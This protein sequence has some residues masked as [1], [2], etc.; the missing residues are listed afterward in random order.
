MSNKNLAFLSC[1]RIGRQKIHRIHRSPNMNP[2]R[3]NM[4]K[5]TVTDNTA[6][7]ISSLPLPTPQ[8]GTFLY[9]SPPEFPTFCLAKTCIPTKMEPFAEKTRKQKSFGPGCHFD[10]P[11][12]LSQRFRRCVYKNLRKSKPGPYAGKVA[13]SDVTLAN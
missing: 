13:R 1:P 12:T 6:K 9:P 4:N 7:V 2:W 5:I 10:E 11:G 3:R 8:N